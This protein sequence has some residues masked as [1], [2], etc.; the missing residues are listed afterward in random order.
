MVSQLY[1]EDNPITP[2]RGWNE[3]YSYGDRFRANV[4]CSLK[5]VDRQSSAVISDEVRPLEEGEIVS[6]VAYI[7]EDH[8]KGYIVKPEKSGNVLFLPL[9]MFN[10]CFEAISEEE[11]ETEETE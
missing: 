2:D 9:D 1:S 6:Y 4:K 5:K 8:N 10:E 7:L 11:E 3:R